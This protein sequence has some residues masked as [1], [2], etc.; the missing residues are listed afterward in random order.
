MAR[1]R[2]QVD[3]HQVFCDTNVEGEECTFGRHRPVRRRHRAVPEAAAP[4]RRPSV[5][6]AATAAAAQVRSCW[7]RILPI[8]SDRTLSQALRGSHLTFVWAAHLRL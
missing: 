4:A 5:H 2:L 6:A 3:W 8:Q 7:L 1:P